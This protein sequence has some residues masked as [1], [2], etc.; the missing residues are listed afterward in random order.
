MD[1]CSVERG[2]QLFDMATG[3]DDETKL[4]V[5]NKG[6][7]CS[8]PRAAK[9]QPNAQQFRE[10]LR[11]PV[12]TSGRSPANQFSDLDSKGQAT[13]RPFGKGKRDLVSPKPGQTQSL[14][15]QSG[16]RLRMDVSFTIQH[17]RE[18]PCVSPHTR[19]LSGSKSNSKVLVKQQSPKKL[20]MLDQYLS[21]AGAFSSWPGDGVG[22]LEAV[23][24]GQ[25]FW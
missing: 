9:A 22:E 19:P 8:V 17:T 11:F 15:P 18:D 24:Y 20:D 10:S 2:G 4:I 7:V 25:A 1:I 3:V 14:R 12:F 23:S 6:I 21:L 5:V 13:H 16:T